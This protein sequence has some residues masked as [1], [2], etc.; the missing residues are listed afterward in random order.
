MHEDHRERVRNRFARE[1]LDAFEEHQVLEL[2]LFYSIPRKDTTA[3][4]HRL[5]DKFGGFSQVLDAPLEELERVEGVGHNSALL[6]KL[7]R[8]SHRYYEICETSNDIRLNTIDQCGKYLMAR[9]NGRKN[10]EIH[11]L[12]LDAKRK[13]INC[14]KIEEG[15]VSSAKLSF[16]KVINAAMT[17][18]AVSVILAHNHPGGFAVPSAEDV[19]ATKRLAKV[20]IDVDVYLLDHIVVNNSEYVSLVASNLY[21]PNEIGIHIG[22]QQT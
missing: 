1:D 15:S 6:L 4:A 16:R 3:I 22:G 14:Q 12:C 9:L 19:E 13:V 11:L 18:N 20:L 21:H 8:S 2:I 10:E 5:I 7:F 17:N